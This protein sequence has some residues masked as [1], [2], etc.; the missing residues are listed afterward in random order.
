MVA[1]GDGGVAV[2]LTELQASTPHEF[3]V[4]TERR[5][6]PATVEVWARGYEN[7]PVTASAAS[8]KLQTRFYGLADLPSPVRLV[9]RTAEPVEIR[10]RTPAGR[11]VVSP[12]TVGP[13]TGNVVV[14]W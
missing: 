7:R 2:L 5:P 10:L 1:A 6:G 9:V 14:R 8:S 11:L 13:D 4:V 12:L 3:H